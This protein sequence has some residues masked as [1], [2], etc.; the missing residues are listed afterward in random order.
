V[1]V[2]AEPLQGPEEEKYE[3]GD[4]EWQRA[5]EPDPPGSLS[6]L[7]VGVGHNRQGERRGHLEKKD[8]RELE[9]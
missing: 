4:H 6:V 8:Y 7:A 2:P 5:V 3:A 9:K 1:Q